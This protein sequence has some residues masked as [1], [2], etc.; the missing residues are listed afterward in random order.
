MSSKVLRMLS[1]M[2]DLGGLVA[3]VE[4]ERANDCFEA[5]GQNLRPGPFGAAFFAAA[6]AQ[7]RLKAKLGSGRT[8]TLGAHQATAPVGQNAFWL[9]VI[10]VEIFGHDQLQHGVAQEF[11]P[12]VVLVDGFFVLVEVGAVGKSRDQQIDVVEGDMQFVLGERLVSSNIH[13]T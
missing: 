13:N 2:K 5:V 4:I 3:L 9:A 7:Q 8:N 6:E 10:S 1:V 12:F 11:Q